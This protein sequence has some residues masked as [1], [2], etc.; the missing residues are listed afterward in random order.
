M[1]TLNKI[2]KAFLIIIFCVGVNMLLDKFFFHEKLEQYHWVGAIFR[3]VGTGLV[4]IYLS[5]R[6]KKR[7]KF[8]S[9]SAPTH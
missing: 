9:N 8:Q 7:A 1:K 5:N 4:L 6:Q 2:G 3:G